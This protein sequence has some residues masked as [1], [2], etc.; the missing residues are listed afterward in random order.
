M[1]TLLLATIV[2]SYAN[3]IVISALT[4]ATIAFFGYWQT[5]RSKRLDRHR[6]LFAD[7][8]RSVVEYREFP[9]KIRRRTPETDS[10]ALDRTAITDALSTVQA[11]LNLHIATLNIETPRI[12]PHYRQMIAETKKIAGPQIAAAWNHAPP[13][14][15]TQM[16]V[17]DIDYTELQYTDSQFIKAARHYLSIRPNILIKYRTTSAQYSTSPASDADPK[18]TI[19]QEVDGTLVND[20]S[21]NDNSTIVCTTEV[22]TG[23]S[24]NN[25]TETEYTT[26]ERLRRRQTLYTLASLAV[27][28]VILLIGTYLLYLMILHLFIRNL[29][30]HIAGFLA[31]SSLVSLYSAGCYIVKYVKWTSRILEHILK[32]CHNICQYYCSWIYSLIKR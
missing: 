26:K 3:T 4:S 7:A 27:W 10:A 21:T 15:D 24:T 17:T 11:Q 31:F 18:I 23:D 16:H 20:T 8:Y 32:Y 22:D 1:N 30:K 6:Q 2:P 28:I 5:A 19:T 29:D 25:Q 14:N 9:Y 13:A 12:A